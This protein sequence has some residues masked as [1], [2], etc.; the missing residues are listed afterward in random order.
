MDHLSLS[1]SKT[2]TPK[3]KKLGRKATSFI[4]TLTCIY[5]NKKMKIKED[6]GKPEIRRSVGLK[7][8]VEFGFPSEKGKGEEKNRVE[9][10]RIDLPSASLPE[11]RGQREVGN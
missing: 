8:G 3:H 7:L 2:L 11:P 5:I 9:D 1:F 4:H 10:V 6:L